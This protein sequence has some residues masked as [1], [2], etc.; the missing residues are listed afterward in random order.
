MHK[1]LRGLAKHQSKTNE[2]NHRYF[3]IMEVQQS[4]NFLLADIK[5]SNRRLKRSNQEHVRLVAT[6]NED[7]YIRIAWGWIFDH[8]LFVLDLMWGV[9]QPIVLILVML[10]V[11][12]VL[13]I[14]FT[15]V[16]FYLLIKFITA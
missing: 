14:F 5:L 7:G 11:R 9:I 15:A 2:T 13:I 10:I 12:I 4:I 3:N 6:G 16:G 8:L 1:T